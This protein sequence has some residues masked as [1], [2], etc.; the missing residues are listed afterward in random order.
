MGGSPLAV[1]GGRVRERVMDVKMS[2][3]CYIHVY[4]CEGVKKRKLLEPA[5]LSS[6]TP[7]ILALQ[8]LRQGDCCESKNN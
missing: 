4:N 5:V 7:A 1:E 8:R 6:V 2:E 3:T